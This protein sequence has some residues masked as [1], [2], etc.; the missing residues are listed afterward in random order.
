MTSLV[1]RTI[2]ALRTEH[3]T[4][5][6]L[7]PNLSEDQLSGPSGASEWTHRAG[8]LAPRQRRRDQA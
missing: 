3:D 7:L 8:A 4:L 6:A 2:A 1:D 5:V